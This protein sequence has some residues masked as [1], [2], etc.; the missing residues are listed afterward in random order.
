[1]TYYD[2]LEVSSRASKEVIEKAYRV[3]AKKYHPDVN[4]LEQRAQCEEYMKA[5]NIAYETL[6]D[7]EKR[8]Q[9]DEEL[10]TYNTP[11]DIH[12][13]GE[14]QIDPEF[15]EILKPRPWPRYFARS[16]DMF[17][18]GLIVAF[19][20]SYL[21]VASYNAITE[22]IS[23]YVLGAVLYCIWIFV[24]SF[25][26]SITATTPGKWIFNLYILDKY[27]NKLDYKTSLKRNF[28]VFFRGLG[29]GIPLISLF[30]LTNAYNRVNTSVF[31][32]WDI[33]CGTV[34]VSKKGSAPKTVLSALM[35]IALVAGIAYLEIY[36]DKVEKQQQ[37]FAQQMNEMYE[38]IENEEKALTYMQ[39]ELDS[40]YQ[41]IMELEEQL[42][43]W[44]ESDSGKY[45]DNYPAYE[46]MIDDYNS[47]LEEFESR[48]EKHNKSI[49]EYNKQLE[50]DNVQ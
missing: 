12:G 39:S 35:I 4:P 38:S 46:Q 2:I 32:S 15:A 17:I 25:I 47:K 1:M 44:Q 18:G 11:E 3:L 43:I 40:E 31:A 37:A 33:D 6:I 10:N 29:L 50:N 30:T 9:Y 48:R 41:E 13:S 20:W 26:T 42:V 14:E 22:K 34:S 45:D 8:R 49:N 27:G 5:I 21:D 7:D 28:L 24:E 36:Q 16:I 23:G 19:A